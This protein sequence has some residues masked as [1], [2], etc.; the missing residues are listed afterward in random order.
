M[1][2]VPKLLDAAMQWIGANMDP[3]EVFDNDKLQDW[4]ESNGFV[5][6]DQ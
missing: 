6:A 3:D 2:E 1:S 4:A 5:K